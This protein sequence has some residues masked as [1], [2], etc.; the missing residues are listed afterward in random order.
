M[1]KNYLTIALRNLVK[2]KL[3]SA[4][5][6]FG[7]AVGLACCIAIALF[8]R[9]ELS[10]DTQWAHAD[11]I[12]RI[13]REFK[14]SNG[15][16]SL[17]LATNAPQAGPLLEAD[18]A[19]IE[20]MGR[21]MG[22]RVLVSRGETAFYEPEFTAAD[23]GF[24]GIFDFEFVRGEP[25][26]ALTEPFTLILTES[27]AQKYFGNEDPLGQTLTVENQVE[28]KV[29][30]VI[31]DLPQTT[32]LE[33]SMIASLPTFQALY[34]ARF[35]EN[36]GSNNFLTYIRLPEGYDIAQLEAQLPAFYT[37]HIAEDATEWTQF[38]PQRL[39]SI[40]LHSNLDNEIGTNG[41]IGVVY[42][43]GAV[44]AFLLII[45]CI[46][47]MNLSA[48]RSM[49]RAKEVGMRKVLGAERRQLIFQFLGESI[50]LCGIAT[51]LAVALV[52]LLLPVFATFIGSELSFDYASDPR[53]AGGL[54][55]LALLVGLVAGSYPAFYI[56]AFTPASVLKGDVTR[57][58]SG[59]L[60]RK[61]LVVT[62]FAISIALI[63]ATGVVYSQMRFARQLD[64]GLNKEQVVTLA[65]SPTGGLGESYQ[66]MKDEWLRL[67]GVVNVTASNL[68]PSNQNT[69][70]MGIRYEGGDPEGRGMPPL[71]VDFDFFETYEIALVAG[72]SFN[73][74]FASDRVVLPT[75][76][77]P[78]TT[79][80]FILNE[81]A[82]RQAGWTP[83]EALGKW[84]E[85][86][87]CDG[88]DDGAVRG[89]VVGVARDIHFSS[90]REA[91]KPVFYFVAPE[92]LFGFPALGIASIRVRPENLDATLA[93]I[94]A[95]W[96]KFLPDQPVVRSFL[97]DR[98]EALYQNERRQGQVFLFFAL[99]ALLVACLGLFGLA[100]FTTE[101]RTKEIGVRKVMGGSVWDIVKLLTWELSKLVLLANLIAWPVAWFL[102]RR[103]LENFAYR[104]DLG[105]MVFLGAA[106]MALLVAWVTVGALA[107]RAATSRPILALRYE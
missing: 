96:Q 48:A 90:I 14:G 98:F 68:V 81:L 46:N 87:I 52:E 69:N 20:E 22:T 41:S 58:K 30:G 95:T 23:Q 82:A 8:V 12:W 16:A 2:H 106:V 34:G 76:E 67:P 62:Q 11:R 103:W 105:P 89:E 74:Q 51:L 107:A 43:F 33:L 47:F 84:F 27:L 78:Q 99:L 92:K 38:H 71:F 104:I 79:G 36:W 77:T 65:G 94:D 72:R 101:T 66:A 42:T 24:L 63:I 17:R 1:L 57:G 50:L 73:Q 91:I 21:L 54:I 93:A 18:F 64:L 9:Q 35:S 100:A 83:E 85:L 19:E 56:S 44:A 88:C 53:V 37:K 3:Y 102:M 59:A 97:D 7:L 15:N 60:F 32:H 70:G 55:A 25:A 45:A 5:N 29:T 40:H 61:G 10:Y 28:L 13:T 6:I 75:A 39:T 26:G 31:R 86:E 49:Q 4:I 80:N